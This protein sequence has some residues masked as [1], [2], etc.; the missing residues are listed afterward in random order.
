MIELHQKLLG[1]RKRNDAFYRALTKVIKGGV[2]TV[3]DIGSGTGF[4]SFLARQLGSPACYLYEADGAMLDLSQKLAKENNITNLHFTQG[5]SDEIKNPPKTDVVVSETLGNFAYDEHL[6]EIM[7]DAQRFLKPGGSIIP[8]RVEQFVTPVIA[9]RLFKQVNVWDSIGYSIGWKT[10]KKAALNNMYVFECK[11]SDLLDEE[12]MIDDC[13][14]TT[15]PSST[16]R[17]NCHW[18]LKE[19]TTVYGFCLW[20]KAHLVKDVTLSTSP[21]Q[22]NSHWEQIFLPLETPLELAAK[23]KLIFE[24]ESDTRYTVGVRMRWM[25]QS[26]REKQ[27]MD[28]ASGLR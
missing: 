22:K 3:T 1:D 10:A 27:Q 25:A 20:W 21:M 12:R 2:S 9:P 23:E 15:K 8:Y 24:F 4:L 14:L 13:N 5:Y 19:Q 7:N 6:I 28:T 17:G 16:R 26:A 18:Q 11:P